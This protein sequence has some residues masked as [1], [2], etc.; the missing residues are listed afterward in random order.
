MS[1]ITPELSKQVGL[2]PRHVNY[3]GSVHAARVATHRQLLIWYRF[4]KSPVTPKQVEIMDVIVYRVK[5]EEPED[6]L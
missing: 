6:E 5:E 1:I 4:L 2:T 3:P